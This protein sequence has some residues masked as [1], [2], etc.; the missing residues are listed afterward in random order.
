MLKQLYHDGV[1]RLIPITDLVRLPLK[2][3]YGYC[4]SELE[5]EGT[6]SE[7]IGPW[8]KG[9]KITTAARYLLNKTDGGAEKV[10]TGNIARYLEGES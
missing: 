1:E 4:R 6:V 10:S 8:Q 7:D 9:D 3:G 2:R 5:F